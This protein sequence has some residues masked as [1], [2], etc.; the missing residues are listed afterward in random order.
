MTRR[1]IHLLILVS[2]FTFLATFTHAHASSNGA[3]NLLLGKKSLDSRE[4]QPCLALDLL[5]GQRGWPVLFN[6]YVSG[7][8]DEYET[9]IYTTNTEANYE[10]GLG[11]AKIWNLGSLHPHASA[12][13]GYMWRRIH[14]DEG[15][16]SER[17][18]LNSSDV[19]L[20]VGTGTFWRSRW[21]L[22][23]GV[24]VRFS[25][26]ATSGYSLGGTHVGITLGWGWP[27]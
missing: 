17:R 3:V 5:W 25:G 12:G 15:E 6:L 27:G 1:Q 11:L 16:T 4:S 20:W 8:W 13:T 9:P 23:L 21:G 7:A 26:L 2:A 14:S 22:D 24:A 10:A 18:R 19:G